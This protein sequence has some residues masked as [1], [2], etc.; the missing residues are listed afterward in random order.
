MNLLTLKKFEPLLNTVGIGLHDAKLTL[1]RVDVMTTQRITTEQEL[2]NAIKHNEIENIVGL[3]DNDQRWNDSRIESTSSGYMRYPKRCRYVELD[4]STGLETSVKWENI[5]C[6]HR[7]IAKFLCKKG[8]KRIL[9]NFNTFNKYV[10]R[11]DILRICLW[12][13]TDDQH[14]FAKN[15]IK[16]SSFVEQVCGACDDDYS[17]MYFKVDPQLIKDCL[18]ILERGTRYDT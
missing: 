5:H 16:H 15:L 14:Y 1:S 11:N 2:K 17:N 18:R 6:K 7:K 4:R 8:R 10:G 3:I 9:N 12:T 13:H